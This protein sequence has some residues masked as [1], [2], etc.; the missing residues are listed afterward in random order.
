MNPN[1]INRQLDNTTLTEVNGKICRDFIGV[2]SGKINKYLYFY[3]DIS[4][5]YHRFYL[6]AGLLFWSSDVN[7]DPENDLLEGDHYVNLGNKFNVTGSKIENISMANCHLDMEFN[8]GVRITLK[9][10][11]QKVGAELI[12]SK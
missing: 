10:D 6:D 4:K 9:N 8:N 2:F 7:F 11:V 1:F 12:E 3:I 5:I